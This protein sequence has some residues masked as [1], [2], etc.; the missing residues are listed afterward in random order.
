[1]AEEWY[2]GHDG[3]RHGPISF[4]ELKQLVAAGQ[5]LPTDLAWKEGMPNWASASTVCDFSD[6]PPPL[7]SVGATRTGTAKQP[8]EI[9]RDLLAFFDFNFTRF[10]TTAVVKW[11]W[12]AWLILAVL[13]L[14]LAV[15]GALSQGTKESVLG[16]IG[17]IVLLGFWTVGIRIW[18]E[19]VAVIFRIAEYLKD[20]SA[21]S[22]VVEKKQE[23]G[24][25]GIESAVP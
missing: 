22:S 13:L 6:A 4:D 5:L 23:H 12:K 21:P 24:P 9:T 20:M 15:I 19:V 7:P 25:Q 17:L 16:F 11:V 14:V 8:G 10:V 18:L 2:Y 1:M 3:K